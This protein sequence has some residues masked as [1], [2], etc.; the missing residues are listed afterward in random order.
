MDRTQE[1]ALGVARQVAEKVSDA[2]GS[3]ISEAAD[4]IADKLKSVPDHGVNAAFDS[5]PANNRGHHEHN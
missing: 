1:Q 4:A 3:A 2:A 5:I